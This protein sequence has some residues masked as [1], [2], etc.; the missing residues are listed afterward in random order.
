MDD[1]TVTGYVPLGITFG[2]TNTDF[3]CLSSLHS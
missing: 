1:G 2:L 3:A